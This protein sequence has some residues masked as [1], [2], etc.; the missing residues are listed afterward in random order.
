MYGSH[1][2]ENDPCPPAR[3]FRNDRVLPASL[4]CQRVPAA[5]GIRMRHQD[6]R[7]DRDKGLTG[8]IYVHII[9]Q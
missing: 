5:Y 9:K 1:D 8:D 4:L 7:V 3:T 2:A 6:E